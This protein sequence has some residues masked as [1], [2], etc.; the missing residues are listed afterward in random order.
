METKVRGNDVLKF[1]V[2]TKNGGLYTLTVDDREKA[3]KLHRAFSGELLSFH[4]FLSELEIIYKS[5][6][7]L[8]DT[9]PAGQPITRKINVSFKSKQLQ[10]P[11]EINN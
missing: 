11:M 8:I 6:N 3:E 7:K 10:Q 2:K 5:G 4:H 1:R 9:K